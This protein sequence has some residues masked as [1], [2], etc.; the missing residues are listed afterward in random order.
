VDW[1]IQNQT[2]NNLTSDL[3]TSF[4][5]IPLNEANGIGQRVITAEQALTNARANSIIQTLQP[6]SQIT[7]ISHAIN[8]ADLIRDL[9]TTSQ[10][11]QDAVLQE[12]FSNHCRDL[13][14]NALDGAE[15]WLKKGFGY[16][17]RKQLSGDGE[18]AIPCP[19]CKQ[20]INNTLDIIKAYTSKFNEAFNSLVQRIERHLSSIQGSGDS[21]QVFV[22]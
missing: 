7:S 20:E 9:Q 18:G 11:I 13:D 22:C 15:G 12:L 16:V 3:I 17:Q 6:L 10:N 5:N 14:N 19:F 1:R 21:F 4:L 2:G 8:F